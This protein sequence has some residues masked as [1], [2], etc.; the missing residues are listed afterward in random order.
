VA[1]IP[2]DQRAAIWN[3]LDDI[4]REK[5]RNGELTLEQAAATTI[6]L[7]DLELQRGREAAARTP[8]GLDGMPQEGFGTPQ[9]PQPG[10]ADFIRAR[11]MP[12]IGAG[13]EADPY[14]NAYEAFNDE[15]FFD[16]APTGAFVQRADGTVQRRDVTAGDMAFGA[17]PRVAQII[18]GA[19][20][21]GE[22]Q[23]QLTYV[24]AAEEMG[25]I[26]PETAFEMGA[27]AR[28]MRNLTK[29]FDLYRR[30]PE[31]NLDDVRNA[32][33][34]VDTAK[35][36]GTLV[37]GQAAY[38]VPDM[39]AAIVPYTLPFYIQAR[40]GEIADQR[41]MNDG[42]Y[43]AE[44]EDHLAALPAATLEALLEKWTTGK[45]LPGGGAAGAGAGGLIGATRRVGEQTAVQ[46]LG[47]GAEEGIAYAGENLG[48]ERGFRAQE[49]LESMAVGA[50]TEGALGGGVETVR[51][52]YAS[53][54]RRN[55]TA[56]LEEQARGAATDMANQAIL[57]LQETEAYG[58]NEVFDAELEA[59]R[60][61]ES[62][63]MNQEG[64]QIEM[65]FGS[66]EIG[67][68]RPTDVD[69]EATRVRE[70]VRTD[71]RTS[72]DNDRT[73]TIADMFSGE[74]KAGTNV[75]T[76]LSNRAAGVQPGTSGLYQNAEE[77]DEA[78]ELRKQREL[79]ARTQIEGRKQKAFEE[80]KQAEEEARVAKEEKK[81]REFDDKKAA[82]EN[83]RNQEAE[84][85][86]T[87]KNERGLLST[88]DITREAQR[89]VDIEKEGLRTSRK[90]IANTPQKMEN[91]LTAYERRR[92]PE[93]VGSLRDQ[94][95]KKVNEARKRDIAR[96]NKKLEE[97]NKEKKAAEAQKKFAASPRTFR[98][99][100]KATSPGVTKRN[101]TQAK[102]LADLLPGNQ[103]KAVQTYLGK[104]A[105]AETKAQDAFE[106]KKQ[107][108][109]DAR[110]PKGQRALDLPPAEGQG[111]LFTQTGSGFTGT[112]TDEQRAEELAR[113]KVARQTLTQKMAA[114]KAKKGEESK[115][116]DDAATKEIEGALNE[117][118]QAV[119]T[120]AG[121]RANLT[122]KKYEGEKTKA[123][124][125]F[126][127][128]E[129]DAQGDRSVDDVKKA[130]AK[131]M[132]A[133]YKANPKPEGVAVIE[134]EVAANAPADVVKEAQDIVKN[135][136]T[137]VKTAATKK[138]KA[139]LKK[140]IEAGAT[141]QEAAELVANDQLTKAEDVALRAELQAALPGTPATV[142][143]EAPAGWGEVSDGPSEYGYLRT[144]LE[145]ELASSNPKLSNLLRAVAN[146]RNTPA[147]YKW[148]AN[149]LAPLVDSL[150]VKLQPV[151]T[152]IVKPRH[153]GVFLGETNAV[154]IQL[155][156]PMTVLHESLHAV[157]SNIMNSDIAM[158]NPRIKAAIDQLESVREAISDYL[159]N[160]PEEV[161]P[162]RILQATQNNQELLAYGLTEG[163]I[164]EF[165]SRIPMPGKKGSVWMA[166][167]A[168]ISKMFNPRTKGQ[169]TALDAVIEA[170]G[171]LVEMNANTPGLNQIATAE[172]RQR[173]G[174][175]FTTTDPQIIPGL[176]TGDRKLTLNT[177][178]SKYPLVG[179][180]LARTKSYISE[181]MNAAQQD[182]LSAALGTPI[183]EMGKRTIANGD[184]AAYK[185]WLGKATANFAKWAGLDNKLILEDG[186]IMPLFHGTNTNQDSNRVFRSFRLPK[187][188]D[189]LG[190]HTTPA[191]HVAAQFTRA[192][193]V[194]EGNSLY[195][196]VG[197][198]S[199]PLRL[200]DYGSWG[201][202]QLLRSAKR[203]LAD[204]P[205]DKYRNLVADLTNANNT[206]V[207]LRDV[208]LANGFDG[209]V[210]LNRGELGINDNV[211]TDAIQRL[212][213]AP[214]LKDLKNAFINEHGTIDYSPFGQ[215]RRAVETNM[216]N[217]LNTI[218]DA[219]F[220]RI[221]PEAV[222]S[223]ITLRE[224]DLKSMTANDG[225][226][227]VSND[228]YYADAPAEMPT[229][230]DPITNRTYI[231]LGKGK[232]SLKF[233]PEWKSKPITSIIDA[234]TAGAGNN[235]V[236]SEVF[237]RTQSE[238]AGMIY[239]AE[240]I[241]NAID[242]GLERMAVKAKRPIDVVRNEF[243]AKVVELEA[244]EDGLTKQQKAKQ[245]TDD[246]GVIARSYF[247]M[248]STIDN[249]SNDILRQR[250]EDPRPFTKAEAGIYQA[251]KAN[252][253]SYYTRVYAHY[254]QGLGRDHA[255]KIW[256]AYTSRIGGST[257][258]K[259]EEGYQIVRDAA[260]H[261]RDHLLLIPDRETMENM[262]I[263]KLQKLANVWGV[264]PTSG[265]DLD[266]PET[267]ETKRELLIDGLEEL[268]T[269]S[270][271]AKD[272]AAIGLVEGL[273]LG[274]ED[275]ALTNYYRGA[276]QDRTVVTK[277]EHV[278]EPIRKLLGEVDDLMIRGVVTVTR[279]AE[280]QARTKAQM[281][282]RAKEMG[283]R[284]LTP[285]AFHDR[286]L[287]RQDWV[288]LKGI[289]Y[290]PL[291]NLW[292]RSDVARRVEDSA[293]IA[294]SLEQS[295]AVAQ[296]RPVQLMI[297]M[298][299]P[300]IRKWSWAAGKLKMA[301]L[302]I[303]P[304]NV[305]MNFG[306]GVVSM[307]SNGNISLSAATR[308]MKTAAALIDSAKGGSIHNTD[309]E[310]V[311]RAGITDSAFMGELR[312]VE[313]D[314]LRQMVLE[315]FNSRAGRVYSKA[316]NRVGEV[317]AGWKELYAMA[318]VVWKIANFY[319]EE[320]MLTAYYKAEGIT[321]TPEMI[322]REAAWSTNIS[323]F[324][325]KRV[326]TLLK[327]VEKAG[328]TFVMPY[329]Y[330]TARAPVGSFWVGVQ[331]M[332]R[333]GQAKTSAGK[334]IL[335]MHG[336]KRILGSIAAMGMIQQAVF[337]GLQYL[338][339][340]MGISD[341]EQE[342][343]VEKL[344]G[345]LPEYKK[346][347]DFFYL[348]EKNGK[349]VVW[350]FS[351]L[352]P[353]GPMTEFY[354]MA[355]GGAEPEEYLD[356]LKNLWINNPYGAGILQAFFGDGNPQTRI[357][358][359]DHDGYEA[360][361]GIVGQRGAMAI[362]KLMPSVAVR[363]FDPRNEAPDEDLVMRFL[364]NVGLEVNQINGPM[365]IEYA[366]NQFKAERNDIRGEWYD[367]LR[368]NTNMSDEEILREY[369]ELTE[370]EDNA[371]RRMEDIYEGL[372][373]VGMSPEQVLARFKSEGLT[374]ADL[375]VL[376]TGGYRPEK[377]GIVSISGLERSFK[378]AV[379]DADMTPADQ[380]RYLNNIR[381]VLSLVQ[382]GK[383]AARE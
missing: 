246:Y 275:S 83:E 313:L 162:T 86:T 18:Q 177:L 12:G 96:E 232:V 279:L 37:A 316:D 58:D 378:S 52:G 241:Y 71:G 99:T 228:I 237:D 357:S 64:S 84:D 67:G 303:S 245:L 78:F 382:Q 189:Q 108:E 201:K 92:M 234:L 87:L 208:L 101:L 68:V 319:A 379:Q 32:E 138:R 51:E 130:V 254:T 81:Q 295:L 49:F 346:F 34:F 294:R 109:A 250:L 65:P 209:A 74:L 146:N 105:D 114:T 126:I 297:D 62:L 54:E 29:A 39:I 5:I 44:L 88:A 167:K 187:D 152:R 159:E 61:I 169:Y 306:G 20:A 367:L 21:T 262:P 271:E 15:D 257:K 13:T 286:N 195:L 353:Y 98:D 223:Y 258:A 131:K 344:K 161:F 327:S 358:R 118:G 280:F 285:K 296:N 3:S 323:N 104:K 46:A 236:I 31:T 351:R 42:R 370:R 308:A 79:K 312:A 95:T 210:Y 28:K 142:A 196:M 288:Q 354:R 212:T 203:L 147:G 112:L 292:V 120:E 291:Q 123:L 121:K 145:K 375:A 287:S 329:I 277:R 163:D 47:G 185:K 56:A 270:P 55:L 149:R 191:P 205:S 227:T 213:Y 366:S 320:E 263:V 198:M 183:Q 321:L 206:D 220:K 151:D 141:P 19:V 266:N 363:A 380:A 170:T 128:E 23:R 322:E 40:T 324:S 307:I 133:W 345:V 330:E 57:D 24:A 374:G 132:V 239:T 33:G 249:L 70:E 168:A 244:M 335:L 160:N 117:V 261:V 352:D 199:N 4:Q 278:P 89:L 115:A 2:L 30:A 231:E 200:Y 178:A 247:E 11:D 10:S 305:I 9:P 368:T 77:T 255:K 25:I 156:Y 259:F 134:Q 45:L 207:E 383:L 85:Q 182:F 173:A 50:L 144:A 301:Q 359:M 348:G 102:S 369:L 342:R 14:V 248:R 188:S 373:S 137:A 230:S 202:D 251:I 225:G 154:Q 193:F 136:A 176:N 299:E 119:A 186:V 103:R 211:A 240:R 272:K 218:T 290:G 180:A 69:G 43:R 139:Q 377:A 179:K 197:R 314:K 265:A 349:P 181:A 276:K 216:R 48:T 82:E 26:S 325:Y 256:N 267:L 8:V 238:T 73:P 376:Y 339:R 340:M 27:T 269:L 93:L 331:T 166:F 222:E 309:A 289:S 233:R 317:I 41:A 22:E 273:L 268:S 107:A 337:H 184:N 332:R 350:E 219:N 204:N 264:L 157:T 274:D 153:A 318:D 194:A 326:P 148:L 361:V 116:A 38:S 253:G 235:K 6:P 215:A 328:L 164:S 125:G 155:A 347:S 336:A 284:I 243:I 334:R 214:D 190:I 343:F 106:A 341:E 333:A 304:A 298:A 293:E 365:A 224:N 381:R 252:L 356:A 282:L 127:K 221:F 192:E 311:I 76:E 165:L 60:A 17:I 97:E 36:V 355:M 140:L 66:G 310:K 1:Y 111:E 150:G 217:W 35:Q 122:A 302:V 338:G 226:F 260:M 129:L 63:N 143:Q 158:R 72:Q 360:L 242:H 300:V 80:Q 171:T 172:A 113:G 91:L 7:G 175:G 371:F 110:G 229:F 59:Q 362:D 75:Q 174:M 16:M 90:G 53:V 372:T 281:E 315:S 135:K 364:T 283:S 100:P 94:R 124:K